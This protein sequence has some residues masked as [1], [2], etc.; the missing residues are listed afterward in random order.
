MAIVS[1]LVAFVIA[2]KVVLLTAA[3]SVSEVLS[4]VP[5]VKAN[6]IFQAVV[7]A[8]SALKAKVIPAT[9]SA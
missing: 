6:G 3:L 5:A 1:T 2:N 9:P 7:N 4:L 8:L